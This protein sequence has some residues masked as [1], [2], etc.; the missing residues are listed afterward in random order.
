MKMKSREV[1]RRDL[2]NLANTVFDIRSDGKSDIRGQVVNPN[3]L[4]N[5][6][7]CLLG[8]N[9]HVH[10]YTHTHAHTF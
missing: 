6:L 9:A 10:T 1:K 8:N 7:D 3:T 2:H 5:N 4:C